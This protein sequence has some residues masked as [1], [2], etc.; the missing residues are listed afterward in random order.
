[1]TKQTRRSFLKNTAAAA[2]AGA[3]ASAVGTA[4]FA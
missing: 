2:G 1:M 3:A 4:A